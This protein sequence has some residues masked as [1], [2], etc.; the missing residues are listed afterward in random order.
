MANM[1]DYIKWRGDLTFEKSAF[2]VPD[3]LVLSMISYLDLKYSVPAFL[4]K[5]TIN[6]CDAAKKYYYGAHP[7]P[8]YNGIFLKDGLD[9][10]LKKVSSCERFKNISVSNYISLHD[11]ALQMQFSATVFHLPDKT[12]FVAFRGTDNS[13]IGWKENFSMCYSDVI[14]AQ[15]KALEYL[16]EISKLFKGKIIVGGHSKGGNLA[17]FA[18][19]NAPRGIRKRILAVYNFDGPGFDKSFYSTRAYRSVKDKCFT[20]IPDNSVVGMLFNKDN[21]NIIKSNKKGIMAHDA[22]SWNIIQNNFVKAKEIS[23]YSK[24]VGK[25]IN[26]WIES[27]SINER[28]ILVDTLFG[29]NDNQSFQRLFDFRE[30]FFKKYGLILKNTNKLDK[31]SKETLISFF[32]ELNTIKGSFRASSHRDNLS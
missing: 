30:L 12:I 7:S 18:S 9:S 23:E 14:S 11:S 27:M 10:I 20:F 22:F 19:V 29:S 2:S 6:I 3:A 25:A 24:K 15:R 4:N 13:L 26:L 16:T 5:E 21:Y 17:M 8:R 1:F 32:R 28:K 31:E